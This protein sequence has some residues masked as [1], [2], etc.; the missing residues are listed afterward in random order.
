MI[1]TDIA[2]VGNEPTATVG[3]DTGHALSDG[4]FTASR[5]A[6]GSTGSAGAIWPG[7]VTLAATADAGVFGKVF[8]RQPS[9]VP[10]AAQMGGEDILEI[11]T[12]KSSA[13]ERSFLFAA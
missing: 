8:S 12:A 3:Q 1:E 5:R 13:P 2:R 11:H 9:P 4:L 6:P 10:K 7:M